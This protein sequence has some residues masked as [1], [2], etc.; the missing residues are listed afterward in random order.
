MEFKL[1]EKKKDS[2]KVQVYNADE[3]L[4]Y[5]L[6]HELLQ[7]KN[8]DDARYVTGHP[9]LDKAILIVKVK[10]GKPQAALKKAAKS[11]SNQFLEARQLVEKQLG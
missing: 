4:I 3:T 2:I 8:V 7:D 9:Q 5:P 6:I 10:E 11:L 1:L